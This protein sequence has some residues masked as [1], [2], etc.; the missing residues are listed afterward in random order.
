LSRDFQPNCAI[1]FFS[2]IFNAPCTYRKI[3]CDGYCNTFLDFGQATKHGLKKSHSSVGRDGA[4]PL[5]SAIATR[6]FPRSHTRDPSRFQF[7]MAMAM[8]TMRRAVAL[9]ARH[10]PAAAA[11]SSRVV[12]LR[13]VRLPPLTLSTRHLPLRRFIPH[14]SPS[15]RRVTVRCLR[16]LVGCGFDIFWVCR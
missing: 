15:R 2:H 16:S 10:I 3:Q 7:Q 14:P 11:A 8:M 9:G 4:L 1:S 12:P 5:A 6:R 13:H